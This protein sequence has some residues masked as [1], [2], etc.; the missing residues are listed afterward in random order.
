MFFKEDPS[1]S[2]ISKLGTG[3][4]IMGIAMNLDLKKMQAFIDEYAANAMRDVMENL[5]PLQMVMASSK[6]GLAGI[7]T[8]EL[9]LVMVG[10]PNANEGISDMNIFVGFKPAGK[11]LAD[12][13]KSMLELS[14]A[15]VE[16]SNKGISA[17][18]NAEYVPAPGQKI[19][20]P[21]GCENFGK[22]GITGFVNLEEVD[23]ASFGLT[24]EEKILK[25]ATEIMV[26]EFKM[27][28]S[29]LTI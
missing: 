10:Q 1:G 11:P 25:Q 13:A 2:I 14:M 17:F 7:L 12:M 19:R 5:G 26:E 9:G 21:K 27:K 20:V 29:G 6:D 23:M 22:K 24:E 28:I 4:P 18:S 3:N 8:G 15:K 16:V